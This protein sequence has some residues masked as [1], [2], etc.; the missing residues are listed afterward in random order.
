MGNAGP[1]PDR[2]NVDREDL[3]P[4]TD[5]LLGDRPS[6]ATR[7]TGDERLTSHSAAFPLRVALLD[8]RGDSLCRIF[9]S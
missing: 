1:I 2:F 6:D 9:R 7:S 5:Q 4:V 8:E 3:V